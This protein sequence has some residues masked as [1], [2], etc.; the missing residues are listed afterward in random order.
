MKPSSAKFNPV[1]KEFEAS[2][3]WVKLPNLSVFLWNKEACQRLG[4]YLKKFFSHGSIPN[5]GLVTCTRI[6]AEMDIGKELIEEV[7]IKLDGITCH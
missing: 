7:S 5:K 6:C 4:N 1:T 3:V 2:S